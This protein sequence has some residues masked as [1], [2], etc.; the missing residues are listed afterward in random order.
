M[1]M[2]EMNSKNS[3]EYEH[4]RIRDTLY[5]GLYNAY[6]EKHPEQKDEA[7]E[8]HLETLVSL[9]SALLLYKNPHITV[10]LDGKKRVDVP[11][12]EALCKVTAFLA[13]R[14]LISQNY[15][16]EVAPIIVKIEEA[17]TVEEK[18]ALIRDTI[19]NALKSSDAFSMQCSSTSSTPQ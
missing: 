19:N 9:R 3:A 12:Y 16:S 6:I 18:E 5:S 10:S 7:I 14:H 2:N 4:L 1:S 11:Y 8:K 13:T 15:K 17:K